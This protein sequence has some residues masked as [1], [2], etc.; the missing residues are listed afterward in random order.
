MQQAIM[1]WK[2]FR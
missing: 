2:N 1:S